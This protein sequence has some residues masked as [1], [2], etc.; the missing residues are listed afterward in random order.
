MAGHGWHY[1]GWAPMSRGS[2][3]AEQTLRSTSSPQVRQTSPCASCCTTVVEAAL[4]RTL[5]ALDADP[6]AFLPR[7]LQVRSAGADQ[8]SLVSYTII[9]VDKVFPQNNCRGL[10]VGVQRVAGHSPPLGQP[11]AACGSSLLHHGLALHRERNEG[12]LRAG[13]AGSSN[14]MGRFCYS[15]VGAHGQEARRK[16]HIFWGG[17]MLTGHMPRMVLLSWHI[18]NA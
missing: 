16:G 7:Q 17:A 1:D 3:L 6:K 13:T 10:P 4:S 9:I 18:L 12:S 11:A 15:G 2:R 14:G 5:R 8:M